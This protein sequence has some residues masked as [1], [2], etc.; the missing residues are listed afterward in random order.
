MNRSGGNW[1]YFQNVYRRQGGAWVNVW[2]AYT[3]LGISA[4]SV[5][6][7]APGKGRYTLGTSYASVTGGNGNLT[8]TCEWVSGN[9]SPDMS[10]S[11]SSR[12]FS[13]QNNLSTDFVG[14][15]TWKWTV[16]DGVSSA[17]VNISVNC[18]L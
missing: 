3:P 13:V 16:S 8:F 14:N 1:R 10:G 2:T 5:Y 7:S 4:S 17:S 18:G 12:T 15:S 6:G 11:G 9:Y